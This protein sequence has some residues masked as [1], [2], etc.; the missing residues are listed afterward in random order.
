MRRHF[1]ANL[2]FIAS[3][4][5]SV[6]SCGSKQTSSLIYGAMRM[7]CLFGEGRETACCLIFL[8]QLHIVLSVVLKFTLKWAIWYLYLC[9][10]L[11]LQLQGEFEAHACLQAFDS[12][13]QNDK[14]WNEP[15]LEILDSSISPRTCLT[16]SCPVL[17]QR[18]IAKVSRHTS[19]TRSF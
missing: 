13:W 6:S 1:N 10:A 15:K 16:H 12:I 19:C 9:V 2:S 8:F 4:L 18:Q 5:C 7:F 14:V 3:K 17:L 11:N